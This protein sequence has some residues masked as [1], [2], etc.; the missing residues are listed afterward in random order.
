MNESFDLQTYMTNGVEQIVAESVKATLK[1]PRESAFMAKFALAS[2]SASKKRR[3]AEDK[4]E[5]I[6]AFLIASI[7]SKCNLHCAG[8]YSR[9]KAAIS[10]STTTRAAAYSTKNASWFRRLY[11]NRKRRNTLCR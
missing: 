9:C 2:R 11:H 1:N 7:T 3:I 10:C 6:P 4:G 5:H 8:C